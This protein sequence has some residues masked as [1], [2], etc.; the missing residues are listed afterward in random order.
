MN[1][2]TG[3]GRGTCL[4]SGLAAAGDEFDFSSS[5]SRSIIKLNKILMLSS[6]LRN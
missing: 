6:P 2:G 5:G 3:G 4:G 1:L